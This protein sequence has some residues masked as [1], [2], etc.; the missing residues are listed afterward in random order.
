MLNLGEFSIIAGEPAIFHEAS[1][2]III[3]DL[4]LGF[5]DEAAESGVFLPKMQ[6]KK[7]IDLIIRLKELTK[8][9]KLIIN[10][11]IKNSFNRLTIQE[12][13][14][15]IRFFGKSKDLY[16]EVILVRGNHDNYVSIIAEKM[17]VPIVE[18][19]KLSNMTILLHGH[20]LTEEIF[21]Y[22]NIII[23]HEHP[24]FTIKDEIGS[25]VKMPCFLKVPLK[26]GSNVI[27]IPAAGY[28]QSGNPISLI[29]ENYLSPI[30][31]EYGIIDEIVPIIIDTYN[32][33]L[34]EFPT[35]KA[36]EESFGIHI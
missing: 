19:Y 21:S 30:I 6:L 1:Q 18:S 8:A 17:N 28:Y 12:R 25:V 13:E 11:D 26:N 31:R 24:S 7:A 3:A 34:I 9:K 33:D 23:G 36:I 29:R 16:D 2:S 27:V 20:K 22:K 32:K 4:H 10:G 15:I 14:E 5:E 35:L